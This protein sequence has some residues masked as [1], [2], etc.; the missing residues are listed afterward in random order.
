MRDSYRAAFKDQLKKSTLPQNVKVT[1]SGAYPSQET[2]QRILETVVF[3]MRLYGTQLDLSGLDSIAIADDYHETLAKL[4]RG[5][6]APALVPSNDAFGT[7][8]AM[9][10]P[11]LR[12]GAVK[13]C[14]VLRSE[15]GWALDDPDHEMH[16]RGM[17]ILAHEAAHAHDNEVLR[18]TVPGFVTRSGNNSKDEF[19]LAT[20]HTCW[21]EYIASRL[22]AQ[23]SIRTYCG[24]LEP[25][26][27]DM[28][29]SAKEKAEDSIHGYRFHRN[30]KLAEGDIQNIFGKIL[31][32]SAY[33]V[34]H[35]HGLGKTVIDMAPHYC[36]L[37]NEQTW[38]SPI[39]ERYE[40]NLREM[41]STYGSWTSVD[42]FSPLVGT[43]EDLLSAGGMR[44]V[45]AQVGS[46]RLERASES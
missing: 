34:G 32:R 13:T 17:H 26:L 45:T 36:K 6:K 14:I 20:A 38:F 33:L 4:D 35:V 43:C 42:V 21:M 31:I 11:V 3:F 23:W 9:A 24:E 37:I 19:L 39:F 1:I 15:L 40:S 22:S 29:S 28:L 18:R 10:V 41:H 16:S 25:R 12:D 46:A 2:A 7:G 30:Q 8:Y 27:C 44:Y 5:F